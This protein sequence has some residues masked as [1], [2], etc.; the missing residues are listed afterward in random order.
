MKVRDLKK[1][2]IYS[3]QSSVEL[4]SVMYIGTNFDPAFGW[5]YGFK[6]YNE[7]S[8]KYDGLFNTLSQ[9]S[10]ENMVSPK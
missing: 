10:V 7:E 5:G 1:G 8:G 2:H 9:K 4:V 3:Y 6:G